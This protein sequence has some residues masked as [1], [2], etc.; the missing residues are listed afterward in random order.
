[1]Y[2][3]RI[4]VALAFVALYCVVFGEDELLK[5]TV[6]EGD[7]SQRA[8]SGD[9]LAMHYTGKL[10]DGKEF[11]SSYKRNDPLELTLGAGMVIKGW[12]EGIQGMCVGEVRELV[13]PPHMGYGKAGYPPVIPE[14]ATL[15]FTVELVKI[16]N[17]GA[18]NQE[19]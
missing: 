14:D 1:M 6:K 5:K 11:D 16:N 18:D 10:S 8:K 3:K 4:T 9:S 17:S 13:I 7:C 12:D 2:S 19:L 15:H